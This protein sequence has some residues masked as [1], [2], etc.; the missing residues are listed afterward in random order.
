MNKEEVKQILEQLITISSFPLKEVEKDFAIDSSGFSTSRFARWFDYKWGKERKYKIW[1]KAHIIS[2]VKTNIITG[3]KIT[4]GNRNDS[5]QLKGLVKKQ[6][7]TLI[8]Q[9]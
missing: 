4:T 6:Q 7:R 1:L 8:F 5:P 2:G 3:I 9:K